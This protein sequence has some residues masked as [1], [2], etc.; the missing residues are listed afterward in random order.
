MGRNVD[1]GFEV[2][3]HDLPEGRLTRINVEYFQYL[4]GIV[5]VLV[6]HGITPIWQPVFHGYGWKGLDT[7]GPVVPPGE[8]ARYCRY[9]VARYGARPA[10]YC[11]ARDGAGTEPQIEAGGRRDPRLGR[12]PPAH[13]HP[14]PAAS[15]SDAHQ[16]A[17]WLDFQACQTGHAGDH[18]PDR[19]ATMWASRPARRS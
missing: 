4:D 11:R 15:R 8:Y 1:E 6:G 2:A 18:V 5:D 10:M 16:D 9:L 19:L 14:L 13:R 7:A 3:F 17:D 12:L